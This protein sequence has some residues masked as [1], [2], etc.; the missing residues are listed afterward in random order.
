VKPDKLNEFMAFTKKY[1]A[2]MKERPDLFKEVKSYKAFSHM[3]G[4]TWGGYVEMIE[5]ESLADLEKWLKRYDS[6]KEHMTKIWPE[7]PPLIVP[8]TFSMNLWTLVQ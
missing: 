5:F 1:L 6:D 8:G 3:L 7:F 4:G 2:W